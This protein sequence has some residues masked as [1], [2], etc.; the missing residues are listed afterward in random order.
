MEPFFIYHNRIWQHNVHVQDPDL[1]PDQDPV[2]DPVQNPLND[3]IPQLTII[4]MLVDLQ[5]Y[6]QHM[7][8]LL[9]L[10]E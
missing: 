8:M 1:D 9:S 4:P 3:S 5:M 10:D 2:P 6:L 7:V